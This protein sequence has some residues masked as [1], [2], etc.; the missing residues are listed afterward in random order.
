MLAGL[1]AFGFVAVMEGLFDGGEL[2]AGASNGE[3]PDAEVLVVAKEFKRGRALIDMVVRDD[4][5]RIVRRV[6]E[7]NGDLRITAHGHRA[8]EHPP[9]ARVEEKDKHHRTVR[10]FG[11]RYGGI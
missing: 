1:A 5:I 10:A 4:G 8:G 7:P 2:G 11:K 3:V 9:F 6:G